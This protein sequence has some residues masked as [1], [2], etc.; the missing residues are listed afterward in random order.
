MPTLQVIL[1]FVLLHYLRNLSCTY[2][3]LFL[4]FTA[5]LQT[6]KRILFAH[7]RPAPNN[8]SFRIFKCFPSLVH[9]CLY[10]PL[11]VIPSSSMPVL[12]F[13]FIFA[14]G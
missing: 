5:L 6:N 8:A 7:S 3:A 11:L 10:L 4:I 2:T 13:Y 1:L 12:K 14:T 9:G